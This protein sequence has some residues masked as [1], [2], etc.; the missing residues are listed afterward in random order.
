MLVAAGQS[1]RMGRDKLWIEILGRPVWRWSLDLLLSI[2]RVRLVA[3]VTPPGAAASFASC[4]PGA[5]RCLLVDGGAT[6]AESVLAGLHALSAAGSDR[7][8]IVLVHDAARP[9]A[10]GALVDRLLAAADE[11]S[12]V[13]PAVAIGDSVRTVR[14]QDSEQWIDAPVD[15][16]RLVATQ[17]PQLARVGMLTDALARA[18]DA[19]AAPADDAEALLAAGV[20]VRAVLGEPENR[21]LTD[22]D[23]EALVRAILRAR[24]A[25]GAAAVIGAGAG[26]DGARVGNGFDAHRLV[27]GRPLRL[28]GVNFPDEPRGLHGHSDGDVALHAVIDA[29]LG[30]AGAG[31]IGRL[32]P[33]DDRWLGVD[34][35]DLLRRATRQVRQAGWRPSSLDLTI[36][37]Q[38]PAV[39][40]RADEMR[41]VLAEVIGI[42]ASSISVKGTTSDGL[43]F[44]GEEGIAAFATAVVTPDKPPV[45]A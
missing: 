13:V 3:V 43:G 4:L 32:F 16:D 7:E 28:G 36:I 9:A 22:P 23:D 38:R 12:A 18:R 5:H 37:A 26:D 24:S 41:A 39:A 11:A 35:V 25:V 33:S 14:S 27:E 31:D 2:R 29:L 1:R 30:A 44:A 34:S 20:S 15:R 8:A 17:T 42:P 45:D 10:T 21:K 40:P 6:R 19:G